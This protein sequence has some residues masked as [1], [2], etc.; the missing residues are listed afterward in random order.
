MSFIFE[1][2]SVEQ[3]S[4]RYSIIRPSEPETVS[5]APEAPISRRGV[6]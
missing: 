4:E 3:E 6:K 2:V 1:E 5:L